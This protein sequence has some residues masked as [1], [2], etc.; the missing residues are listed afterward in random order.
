MK[1]R[2]S[3][4]LD[5]TPLVDVVFLLLIFFLVT[6]VFKKDELALMLNLPSSKE[7]SKVIDKKELIIELSKDEI[8]I[9]K[10]ILTF[11]EID[12]K[13]ATVKDKERPIVVR[14]DKDVR[15]ERIIK[16]FDL[17]EKY[18][19]HNLQLVKESGN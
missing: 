16:L 1:R 4:T 13:F 9:N 8:A 10:D 17:L 18:G 14:I 15:Y 12:A 11:E 2:E 3:L 19:L 6:S 7:G 5:M